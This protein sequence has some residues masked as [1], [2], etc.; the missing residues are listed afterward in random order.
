MVFSR[1]ELVKQQLSSL[2]VAVTPDTARA[3]CP[4]PRL[5]KLA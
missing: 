2:P 1:P 3:S 5:Q 4:V